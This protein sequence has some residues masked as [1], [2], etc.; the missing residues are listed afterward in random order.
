LILTENMEFEFGHNK[1]AS[2]KIK[3]DEEIEIYEQR[4]SY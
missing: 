4:K 3:H 1:S 2:N